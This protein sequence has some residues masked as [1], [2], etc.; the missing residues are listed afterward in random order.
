MQED[1]QHST[2]ASLRHESLSRRSFGVGREADRGL[3]VERLKVALYG[4]KLFS[5]ED[6]DG[7]TVV[8]QEVR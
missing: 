5:I 4:P 7:Y 8:L 1:D 2:P 3:E 6:P